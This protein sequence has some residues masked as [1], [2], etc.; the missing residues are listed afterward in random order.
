M[1]QCRGS[2]DIV[3]SMRRGILIAAVT[4]ALVGAAS[5]ALANIKAPPN[6]YVHV[7]VNDKKKVEIAKK[8]PIKRRA[9]QTQVS[10]AALDASD[11]GPIRK[12][13]QVRGISEV[14]VSVTCTEPMRQC[15]GSIYKY[16]P[17]VRAQLVIAKSKHATKG[18]KLGRP[19]TRDCSQSYPNRNHHCTLLLDRTTRASR[20]CGHCSLNVVLTAWHKKARSNDVLVVGADSDHGIKQKK[21]SISAAVFKRDA[22]Q[23]TR[24]YRSKKILSKRVPV[25]DKSDNTKDAVLASV[26]IDGLKKGEALL[27]TARARAGVGGLGYNV[28]TQSELIVSQKGP[29]STSNKG[30]PVAVISNNGRI[31]TETGYNC[32]RGASDYRDPCPINKAG[33][34][35]LEYSAVQKPFND[36]GRPVP[37]Y[38]NLVAGFGAQY[39][40]PFH[41]GDKVKVKQAVIRVERIAT[42]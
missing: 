35:Y 33:A 40:K 9:G 16:S 15:I 37:L 38:V 3:P 34:A 41:H 8:I 29:K 1:R 30:L 31:A 42:G 20:S 13:Q 19:I 25:V 14:E 6:D 27:V 22:R 28:L 21:A 4:A 24:T 18:E 39:G 23:A 12:G 7:G 26:R 10:V 32:T 17:H 36:K 11:L 2:V 5:L